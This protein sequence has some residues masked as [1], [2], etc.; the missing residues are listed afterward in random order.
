LRELTVQSYLRRTSLS[1][2]PSK[3]TA[4][5]ASKSEII[6]LKR[7]AIRNELRGKDIASARPPEQE[8]FVDVLIDVANSDE[9]A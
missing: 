3:H 5:N 7:I 6:L 9:I 1:D 2:R 8:S 4:R